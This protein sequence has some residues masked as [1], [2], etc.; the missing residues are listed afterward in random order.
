[1]ASELKNAAATHDE[2]LGI[3]YSRRVFD[4]RSAM[5]RCRWEVALAQMTSAGFAGIDVDDGSAGALRLHCSV[6]Q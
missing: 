6:E 2:I 4:H 1:V 3:F 5:R